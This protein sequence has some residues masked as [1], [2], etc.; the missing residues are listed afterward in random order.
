MDKKATNNNQGPDFKDQTREVPANLNVPGAQAVSANDNNGHVVVGELPVFKDQV[1]SRTM[2]QPGAQDVGGESKPKVLPDYKHQVRSMSRPE[3]DRLANQASAGIL[4]PEAQEGGGDNMPTALPDYKHQVRSVSPPEEGRDIDTLAQTPQADAGPAAVSSSPREDL[5]SAH[6]VESMIG[7][8]YA[9]AV[10]IDMRKERRRLICVVL[11]AVAVVAAIIIPVVILVINDNSAPATESPT[12][13]SPTIA[14]APSIPPTFAPSPAPSLRPTMRPTVS[15]Y[16]ST[17]PTVPQFFIPVGDPIR[18]NV[19]EGQVVSSLSFNGTV[20]AVAHR[21]ETIQ[22]IQ[23]YQRVAENGGW[24]PLGPS[25]P[26]E[27]DFPESLWGRYFSIFLAPNALV[28][29]VGMPTF[30][31]SGRVDVYEY[32]ETSDQ[33]IARGMSRIGNNTDQLGYQVVLSSDGGT[34][35]IAANNYNIDN[36]SYAEVLSWDTTT[37]DWQ[38]LGRVEGLSGAPEL[39]I[40]LSDPIGDYQGPRLA[41]GDPNDGIVGKVLVYECTAADGCVQRGQKMEGPDYEDFFGSDLS[42]SDDGNFLAIGSPGILECIETCANVRVME[43]GRGSE[44][45]WT[46]VGQELK[47]GIGFGSRV[48]LSGDG[49][50]VAVG[51]DIFD[52]SGDSYD[53]SVWTQVYILANS[54]V[55][56]SLGAPVVSSLFLDMSRDASTIATADENGTV[57]MLRYID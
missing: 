37:E 46:P 16:P 25:L 47:G 6:L 56:T 53:S 44:E 45:V 7:P 36:G 2:V 32:S 42:F 4:P 11:L 28:L 35:A 22:V 50:T 20:A 39:S 48:K 40:A 41:L 10:V 26:V 21:N 15:A 38:L 27:A 52:A 57:V 51:F 23:V 8:V 14:I 5:V 29:A 13:T 33:W 30:N 43:Y 18:T 19:S 49:K 31:G 17:S 3:Q 54:G 24:F 1:Q 34:L 55:W 9:N 12:T